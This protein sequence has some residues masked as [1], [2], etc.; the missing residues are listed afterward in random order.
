MEEEKDR[1]DTFIKGV[2]VGRKLAIKPA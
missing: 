2:T 1:N